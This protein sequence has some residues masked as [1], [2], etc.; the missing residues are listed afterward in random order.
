MPRVAT[1]AECLD[2]TVQ[3]IICSRPM[4]HIRFKE[5]DALLGGVRPYLA[6]VPAA[7]GVGK[8]TFVHQIADEWAED[9]HP[10]LFFEGELSKASLLSK[11]LVRQSGNAL[12]TSDLFG[13]RLDEE[14]RLHF[15]EALNSYRDSIA[16]RMTIVDGAIEYSSMKRIISETADTYS[17]SPL[18][19]IDYAQIVT[20]PSDLQSFDERVGLKLVSSQLRSIVDELRCPLIAISSIN[21]QN[22]SKQTAGLD[23]IGGCNSF[24]YAADIVC[25]LSVDGKDAA[26]RFENMSSPTRT[27]VASVTKNR[28]ELC[29]KVSF[30]FDAP[31]AR[32]RELRS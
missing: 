18:V 8:T 6:M 1:M 27:V 30:S 3:D 17:E 2:E 9:G 22:Y 25:G 11:S 16:P 13:S 20:L 5:L 12:R 19:I 23:S 4:G 29:G 31:R 32:F 10:S 28:Y 15:D 24:E 7:P 21:R 14:T 26:A